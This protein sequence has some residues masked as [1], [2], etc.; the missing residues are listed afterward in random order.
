MAE[1]LSPEGSMVLL[2][3]APVRFATR[4]DSSVFRARKR[5]VY[6][7]LFEECGLRVQAVTGVDPAPFKPWLLPYLPRLPRPLR[8]FTL[9]LATALSVPADLIF[10]R[11]ATNRSWH[12][13]FVL[14]HA[15]GD[16]YAG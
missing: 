9:A 13:V 14:K 16:Q 8:T 10:G 2:E 3:A 7:K 6:L 5:S 12:A 1:H 15:R 11:V 4:C